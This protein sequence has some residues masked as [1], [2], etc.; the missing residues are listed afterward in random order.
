[1]EISLDRVRPGVQA[2]VSAIEAGEALTSRLRD[3]GLVP[4]TRVCCCYRSPG[5]QVTA[6]ELRGTVLALRTVDLKGIWVRHG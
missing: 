6:L 2:V 4:G 1:M 3:F 5:G